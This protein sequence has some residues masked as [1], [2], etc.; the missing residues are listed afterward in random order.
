MCLPLG[1]E[2]SAAAVSFRG[3]LTSS[4]TSKHV[5][6]HYFDTS[7]IDIRIKAAAAAL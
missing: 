3:L 1:L 2:P 5:H 6:K 7:R 4:F